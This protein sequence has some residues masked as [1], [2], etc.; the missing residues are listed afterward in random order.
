MSLSSQNLEAFLA[1]SEEGNFTR[2]SEKLGLSQSA[3]SQRI[4][5]LESDLG[6][7]LFSRSRKGVSL[8]PA[9]QELLKYC[10]IKDSLE[11]DLL[12][13][14]KTDIRGNISGHIRIGGFSSIMRSAVLPALADLLQLNPQL[15]FTFKNGEIDE[16]P[17]LLNNGEIDYM[18]LYSKV[19]KMG[20]KSIEIGQEINVLC[21]KVGYEGEEIYLDHDDKDQ[22]TSQYQE[23][24]FPNRPQYRRRYLDDVYGLIDG[25]K[26]G[27][28]RAILPRHLIADDKKIKIL[29]PTKTLEMPIYLHYRS[30]PF[31]PLIHQKVVD[32][33]KSKFSK[34]I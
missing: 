22:V 5:N 14:I 15:N 8:T 4:L 20:L 25:V 30:Q 11:T 19:Q 17:E 12:S 7:I 16:L 28:G 13:R 18:I 26:L 3:L 24:Y 9:G 21:E 31:Y 33:L 29:H 6:S 10:K 27:L 32:A 2:A 23:E 1:C 34:Y